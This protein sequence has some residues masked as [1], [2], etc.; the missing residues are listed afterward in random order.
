M[1]KSKAQEALRVAKEI[2]KDCK[3]GTDFHNAFF[4]IYGK[5]GEMFPTRAEREEFFKTPEYQEIVQMRTELR[6]NEKVTM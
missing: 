4:G 5:F 2:A 1:D 3:S 6:K